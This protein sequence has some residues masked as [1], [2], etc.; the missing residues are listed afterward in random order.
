VIVPTTTAGG[1]SPS[2]AATTTTPGDTSTGTSTSE[3][4]AKNRETIEKLLKPGAK[5]TAKP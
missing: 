1:V 3:L 4:S 2:G 5:K